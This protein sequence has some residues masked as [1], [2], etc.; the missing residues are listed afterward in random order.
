[1]QLDRSMFPLEDKQ[2]ALLST[3]I[4]EQHKQGVELPRLT[5]DVVEQACDGGLPHLRPFER[6]DRLLLM[7]ANRLEIGEKTDWPGF[8][9]DPEVLA[10]TESI[11]SRDSRLLFQYLVDSNFVDMVERK[12]NVSLRGYQRIADLA[13]SNAQSR[14]AFVAMWFDPSMNDPRD[15]IKDAIRDLG[16]D[17]VVVDQADF[18]NKICDKIEVEIRRSR[19]L[20]ADFTHD[21]ETG[22]R[23]S[24]Y[25]EAGLAM[26]LSIPVIWTCRED[27]ISKLHFDTRQYSHIRLRPNH[28]RAFRERLR[29]RISI[30]TQTEIR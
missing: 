17:P 7:M 18:H 5:Q 19:F 16:Y 21:A 29:D 30:L 14:I 4:V 26:G 23:G 20:I 2:R 9:G 1:M 15:T 11:S 25:Y 6:A 27:Q 8:V 3:W 10:A 13:M 12:G 22:V 28:M 24:V